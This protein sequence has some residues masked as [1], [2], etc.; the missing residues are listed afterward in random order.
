MQHQHQQPPLSPP[1]VSSIKHHQQQQPNTNQNYNSHPSSTS[2]SPILQPVRSFFRPSTSATTSPNS[3]PGIS[4]VRR[5]SSQTVLNNNNRDVENNINASSP[6]STSTTATLL[7]DH[8]HTNNKLPTT[9]I[10]PRRLSF[11]SNPL[12]RI[13]TS[14]HESPTATQISTLV[15]HSTT[16]ATGTNL[17]HLKTRFLSVLGLLTS[18]QNT[19]PSSPGG[20]NDDGEDTEAV[21]NISLSAEFHRNN[22]P[23][24]LSPR[25]SASIGG[26]PA[27]L[28]HSPIVGKGKILSL[29]NSTT[30]VTATTTTTSTTS[31]TNS[32][33]S[34]TI[35]LVGAIVKTP[36]P[37]TTSIHST[38]NPVLINT[39]RQQQQQQQQ[40]L[41][42]HRLALVNAD[43]ARTKTL[44]AIL[45]DDRLRGLLKRQ[46]ATQWADENVLFLERMS[47]FR[48]TTHA[49]SKLETHAAKTLVEDFILDSAHKQ[50]LLSE[51]VRLDILNSYT[52]SSLDGLRIGLFAAE[53]ESFRDLKQADGFFNFL[54]TLD[55]MECAKIL[56]NW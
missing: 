24:L 18:P 51:N 50:I 30:T 47:K 7:D 44:R 23:L 34:A 20:D 48:S 33:P 38:S 56:N 3:G 11:L 36:P 37:T 15:D 53:V 14:N 12:L 49:T 46:L 45:K 22:N 42:P 32:P 41:T 2:S 19:A 8:H 29:L 21:T 55:E 43:E 26:S 52:L 25:T 16:T 13:N 4:L 31:T 5:S 40:Q 27:I 10:T 54:K 6:L 1:P 17:S 28:N 35:P 39:P 9:T